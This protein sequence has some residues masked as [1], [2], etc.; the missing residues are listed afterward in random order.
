MAG[1]A[2]GPD[3]LRQL[4]VSIAV[5]V[6]RQRTPDQP[7][8]P[9][10]DGLLT[11][12]DC[13]PPFSEAPSITRVI[14]FKHRLLETAWTNFK[15]WASPASESAFDQFRHVQAH[16]LDDYALFRALKVRHNRRPIPRLAGRADPAC[17]GCA[18]RARRELAEQIDQVCLAQF[19]VF[20][21]GERLKDHAQR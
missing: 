3:G 4:S 13:A 19:L 21:Q 6:R 20:R 10:D 11:R 16:W 9:I 17:P 15:R 2:A 14:T 5:I 18:G 12:S 1:P 7:G 8:G